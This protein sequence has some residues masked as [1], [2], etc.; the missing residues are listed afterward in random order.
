MTT[1]DSREALLALVEKLQLQLVKLNEDIV[2]RD[3]KIK[4]LSTS[5]GEMFKELE[6]YKTVCRRLNSQHHAL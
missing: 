2:Q 4:E 3:S 1:D 6:K 5:N